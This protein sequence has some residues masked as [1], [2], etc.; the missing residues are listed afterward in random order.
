MNSLWKSRGEWPFYPALGGLAGKIP[1][2]KLEHLTRITKKPYHSAPQGT[3]LFLEVSADCRRARNHG[4]SSPGPAVDVPIV[5]VAFEN[6]FAVAEGCG[7]CAASS[8]RLT[9]LLASISSRRIDIRWQELWI[10][11]VSSPK[12]TSATRPGCL[13]DV[14]PEIAQLLHLIAAAECTQTKRTT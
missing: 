2:P 7:G 4:R 8:S 14:S 10:W 11:R 12:Q 6:L 3:V 9:S 13:D 1:N 5:C